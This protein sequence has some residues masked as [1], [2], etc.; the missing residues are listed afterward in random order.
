MDMTDRL[1]A[2]PLSTPDRW[3]EEDQYPHSGQAVKDLDSN[4]FSSLSDVSH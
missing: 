3:P 2:L 4:N 1:H